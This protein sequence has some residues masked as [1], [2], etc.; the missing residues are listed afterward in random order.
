MRRDD[1]AP[2]CSGLAD[3][4]SV[5]ARGDSFRRGA[6]S[7]Q[8]AQQTACA[9]ESFHLGCRLLREDD[10]ERDREE[11]RRLRDVSER[12][13]D[14]RQTRK[15]EREVS[16]NVRRETS[17]AGGRRQGFH[18]FAVRQSLAS[19]ATGDRSCQPASNPKAQPPD[20]ALTLCS[21]H[22]ERRRRD[23][24]DDRDLEPERD[25]DHFRDRSPSS[26]ADP[27]FSGLLPP[28]SR[29]ERWA[30]SIAF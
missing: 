30:R 21:P 11:R 8:H 5:S 17:P 9:L 25:R 23:R 1:R 10:L 18:G 4:L 6:R 13:R 28:P 16:R 27:D 7:R 2:P 15:G 26:R 20:A 29:L 12:D 22:L 24:D 19:R 3:G 14:L